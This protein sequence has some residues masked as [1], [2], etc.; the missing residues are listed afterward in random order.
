MKI[1]QKESY[2]LLQIQIQIL[3][4]QIYLLFELEL[5][6]SVSVSYCNL[7]AAGGAAL[8]TYKTFCDKIDFHFV[9][10]KKRIEQILLTNSMAE[11]QKYFGTTCIM[12]SISSATGCTRL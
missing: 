4:Q 2:I 8:A 6:D 1:I 10:S 11:F 5:P 12:D 9:P 3:Y 7:L